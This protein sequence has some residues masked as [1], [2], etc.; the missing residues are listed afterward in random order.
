MPIFADSVILNVNVITMNPAA[1]EC[2]AVAIRDGRFLAVGELE[3]V[4]PFIGPG[5][6]TIDAERKA[7]CCRGS[8]MPT[9]TS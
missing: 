2:T 4:A 8:L 7:P 1:P 6:E 5:T 3:D 9:P